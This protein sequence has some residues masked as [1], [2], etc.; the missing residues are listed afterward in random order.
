MFIDTTS[1]FKT[2]ATTSTTTSTTTTSTII[3][4]TTIAGSIRK[5]LR[6]CNTCS[7]SFCKDLHGKLQKTT[8]CRTYTSG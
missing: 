2:T 1:T 7:F 5:Y 4:S 6:V 8:C 3:V